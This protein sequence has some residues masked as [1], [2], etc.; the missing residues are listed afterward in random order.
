MGAIVEDLELESRDGT[1]VGA[2]AGRGEA[3]VQAQFDQVPRSRHLGEVAIVD[4]DPRVAQTGLVFKD[5]LYDE[6]VG[7]HRQP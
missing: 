1:V 2:K 7:S 4:G 3:E 6:N 5:M